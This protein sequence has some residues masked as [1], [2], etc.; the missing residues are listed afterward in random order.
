ML[1]LLRFRKNL[2]FLV[3][4]SD[5][6]ERQSARIPRWLNPIISPAST[7]GVS[8]A[9]EQTAQRAGMALGVGLRAFARPGQA[10]IVLESRSGSGRLL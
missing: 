9:V 8:K 2:K 4:S 10:G 1:L 6:V 3:G 5:V 7:G